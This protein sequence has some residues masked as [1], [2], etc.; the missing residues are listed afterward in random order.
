MGIAATSSHD[1]EP[2]AVPFR[3]EHRRDRQE[4]HRVIKDLRKSQVP[5]GHTEQGDG[6]IDG[7]W[8]RD[9]EG[10]HQAEHGEMDGRNGKYLATVPGE[11]PDQKRREDKCGDVGD[12]ALGQGKPIQRRGVE[13]E[14]H[15]RHFE[16]HHKL[17]GAIDRVARDARL[18]RYRASSLYCPRHSVSL[19]RGG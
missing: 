10:N 4:Q 19:S 9:R 7:E 12:D 18:A 15:D 6:L 5:A 11:Q 17:R 13:R 16:D 1:R 3:A 8:R 2:G 14:E